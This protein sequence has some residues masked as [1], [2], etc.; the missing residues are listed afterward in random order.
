MIERQRTSDVRLQ[1]MRELTMKNEV[2]L[3]LKFIAN[4]GLLSVV[5][6]LKSKLSKR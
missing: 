6:C 4:I 5:C 3:Q 2:D 1:K